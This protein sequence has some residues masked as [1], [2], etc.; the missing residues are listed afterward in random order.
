[1]RLEFAHTFGFKLR[2]TLT[3]VYGIMTNYWIY[4]L[5]SM[6]VK[7]HVQYNCDD[8]DFIKNIFK[9]GYLNDR[10][11]NCQLIVLL[12]SFSHVSYW[13]KPYCLLHFRR[14]KSG[15]FRSYQVDR[16][17]KNRGYVV[18]IHLIHLPYI[19]SKSK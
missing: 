6:Q 19:L 5:Q 4:I 7:L 14:L 1:M 10:G 15:H 12:L 18:L 8:F 13:T 16:T 11:A 9:N 3:I 17:N 2:T